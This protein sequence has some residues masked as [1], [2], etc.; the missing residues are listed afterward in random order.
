MITAILYALLVIAVLGA[1]L[2]VGLAIADKKFAVEKD[3]RLEALEA[4]MPGANCGGC[5]FAG[6][7]AY[8]EAVFNGTAQPGLCSPGGNDLAFRMGQIMGVEV[9]AMEKQVAYVFC[10]GGCNKTTKDYDYSGLMDCNAASLLFKGDNACK[11]G[12]IH[13]GSCLK[14]CPSNAIFKT[15]EGDI[16]VDPELCTGCGSCTKVCPNGVIKLIPAS[17]PYVVACNN[18]EKGPEVRKK[19]TEGCIGCKLCQIK[20]PEGGFTVTNFLSVS[21]YKAPAE[22]AVKAAQ[23]CPRKIIRKH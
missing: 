11:E 6:C 15:E 4:A 9:Q 7:S 3:S 17:A 12:C 14:V 10:K 8:A 21:D 13:L 22:E 1:L 23:L 16:V 19:C 20:V 2:G 18:H 5:G